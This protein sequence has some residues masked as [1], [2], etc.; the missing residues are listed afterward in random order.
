MN[1]QEEYAKSLRDY[2]DDKNRSISQ[3][4]QENFNKHQ[5]I[6]LIEEKT[7]SKK[8]NFPKSLQKEIALLEKVELVDYW[9]LEN[10]R[11]NKTR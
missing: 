7:I 8:F 4:L 3:F 1:K 2:A 11:T 9:N 6:M 5:H 10:G